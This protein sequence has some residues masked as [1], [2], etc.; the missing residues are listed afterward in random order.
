MTTIHQL[1]EWTERHSSICLWTIILRIRK[2]CRTGAYWS[3]FKEHATINQNSTHLAKVRECSVLVILIFSI[4]IASTITTI[5]STSMITL[6][7]SKSSTPECLRLAKIELVERVLTLV[8][9]TLTTWRK[10]TKNFHQ[11]TS[12]QLLQILSMLHQLEIL[13][14]V[15]PLCLRFLLILKKKKQEYF[16]IRCLLQGSYKE[17]AY[18]LH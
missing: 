17:M 8:L 3:Q 2:G 5:T 4:Q 16:L 6:A 18:Y 13:A 15:A 9:P 11:W 10:S 7:A 12:L 1:R 14:R